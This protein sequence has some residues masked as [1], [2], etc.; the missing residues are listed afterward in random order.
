MGTSIGVQTI[1]TTASSIVSIDN[2]TQFVTLHAN[3]SVYVGASDVTSNNGIHLQNNE[4]LQ[5][6]LLEGC[7]LWAVTA[8]GTN[9]LRVLKV[10]V[11]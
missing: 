9:T 11:E 3:G 8:S 7:D 6:T 10:R 4:T 1:S 5:L 2:V